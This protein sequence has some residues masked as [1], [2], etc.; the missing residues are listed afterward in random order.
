[1]AYNGKLEQSMTPGSVRP[2]SRTRVWIRIPIDAGGVQCEGSC[3]I[4]LPVFEAD[5][6]REGRD[7]QLGALGKERKR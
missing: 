3:G 5:F 6:Q 7:A 4:D 1:M 2:G